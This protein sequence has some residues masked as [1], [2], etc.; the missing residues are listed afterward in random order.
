MASNSRL[1]LAFATPVIVDRVDNAEAINAAL[2]PLI[3]A[4]R[5][6][7][8]GIARSN[9]GGWHSDTGLLRWAADAVRPVVARM[10]ELADAHVVDVQARPGQRRGWM[11]D[12]WA[13]VNQTGAANAPHSHGASFWSAVYYVRVDEG[14]G[15]ELVLNDPRMPMIE[16]H[17][18]FLYFRDMG[19]ERLVRLRPNAGQILLF[20][21]WLVHSVTPWQGEGLRISIAVNLSAPPLAGGQ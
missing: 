17:A 16:M 12:A 11:L 21:S 10:V 6:A 7:D 5:Q 8:K 2:E 18:P 9:L 4:R 14:E 15:G 3:L 19:G 13:N 20:P 1:D